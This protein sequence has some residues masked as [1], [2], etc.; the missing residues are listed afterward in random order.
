LSPHTVKDHLEK[1]RAV[2][3]VGS[4]TEIVATALR[5]GLV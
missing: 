1:I 4:R 3:N 5:R 2:L